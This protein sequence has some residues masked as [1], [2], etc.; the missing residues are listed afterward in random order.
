MVSMPNASKKL[1][2]SICGLLGQYSH[3][4]RI[5]RSIAIVAIVALATTSVAG[6]VVAQE[7]F[8]L[9][10]SWRHTEPATQNTPAFSITQVF[11]PD[12]TFYVEEMIAP[13][14]GMVGT[15]LRYGG[16]YRGTSATSI[17]YQVQSF[18]ACSS[19]GACSSCPGDQMTCA[20][21]QQSGADP[22]VQHKG[23][24]QM[25]GSNEFVDKSGQ[26]WLR[27]R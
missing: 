18:Q 17:V 12:G 25:R 9:I 5:V 16:R 11:N 4:S 22:G 7:G 23:N 10:G 13:R 2:V 8:P 27:I 26:Q 1:F 6:S 21:A 14:P 24:F 15:I 20:L 19:G 3:C